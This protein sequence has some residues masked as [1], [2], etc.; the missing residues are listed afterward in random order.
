MTYAYLG[1]YDDFPD[2]RKLLE[3]SGAVILSIYTAEGVILV[4][5]GSALSPEQLAVCNLMA[6]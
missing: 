4:D 2:T 3:L 5:L 1:L 6:V